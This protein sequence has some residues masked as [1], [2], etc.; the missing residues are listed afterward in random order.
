MT[1]AKKPHILTE[2]KEQKHIFFKETPTF[3]RKA[4]E[5]KRKK[6]LVWEEFHPTEL[7]QYKYIGFTN[8][9]GE[10]RLF[11]GQLPHSL[12]MAFRASTFHHLSWGIKKKS[13]PPYV[14]NGR[15]KKVGKI[16]RRGWAVGGWGGGRSR[17]KRIKGKW[18]IREK[19]GNKRK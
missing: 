9:L 7:L 8:K 11:L 6:S 19:K 14:D 2:N 10:H 16:Y 5:K 17:K 1:V 15:K 13:L 4:Y 12:F 18:R 3:W